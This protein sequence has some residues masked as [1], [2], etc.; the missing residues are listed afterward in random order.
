[1]TTILIQ[2][3]TAREATSTALLSAAALRRS[4]SGALQ[5]RNQRCATLQ[6]LIA[7]GG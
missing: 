5:T 7:N 6:P 3:N 2:S 1:M 4:L